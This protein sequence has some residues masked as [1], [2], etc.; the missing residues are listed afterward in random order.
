MIRLPQIFDIFRALR[1]RGHP[2]TAVITTDDQGMIRGRDRLQWNEVATVHAFKRDCYV[3]DQ[4]CLIFADRTRSIL[5][6]VNENE[7]GYQELIDCLPQ[8]LPGCAR[9]EDWWMAVAFPA[10]EAN[11]TT[12]YECST[13]TSER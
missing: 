10:F 4:I 13:K 2:A 6:E 9:F 11:V 8:R 7:L 5:L 1:K 3:V 12:V